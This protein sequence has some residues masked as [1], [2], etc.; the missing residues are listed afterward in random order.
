VGLY[1][2]HLDRSSLQ[3]KYRAFGTLFAIN[4]ILSVI[5]AWRVLAGGSRYL[6][7]LLSGGDGLLNRSGA[8][9]SSNFSELMWTMF[10]ILIDSIMVTV[11]WKSIKRFALGALWFRWLYGFREVE[12]VFRQPSTEGHKQFLQVPRETGQ[13][14]DFFNYQLRLACAPEIVSGQER[15]GDS[16]GV[17]IFEVDYWTSAAA[18]D[19]LKKG[20]IPLETWKLS[21]WQ[22]NVNKPG[23]YVVHE[24]WKDPSWLDKRYENRVMEVLEAKLQALDKPNLVQTIIDTFGGSTEEIQAI[25]ANE[26][27]DYRQVLAEVIAIAEGR[28]RL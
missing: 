25:F 24:I 8:K 12:V 10:N 1:I 3:K 17:G 6:P 14:A 23:E 5:F 15:T 18:Y 21:V 26:G 2:T 16:S 19:A 22:K 27:L 9:P 28:K 13:S 11:V 7:I 20:E 4:A